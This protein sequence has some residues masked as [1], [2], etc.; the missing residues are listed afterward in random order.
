MAGQTFSASAPGKVIL[1]GEHAVVYGYPAIAVPVQ[2]LS[3]VVTIKES[4]ENGFGQILIDAPD[5]DLHTRLESL[6]LDHP[7]ALAITGT[8]SVL[9]LTNPL[10]FEIK[11]NSTI[12][13]AGGLGS[14]AAVSVAI[15]RALSRFFKIPLTN[16]QISNLAY[17]VE[18][19]H[20]GRPSGI[21]NTVITYAQPIFFQREKPFEILPP[22]HPFTLLI[23]DTGIASP[24]ASAV[25]GVR[26]RY[27]EN[28]NQYVKLFEEI[29]EISLL[30]RNI[31]NAQDPIQL[32]P[33]MN[34]NH[35]LLQQIG[36]SCDSLDRL[37][38]SAIAAGAYGAKLSGGGLG[39]N[40]IAL[41]PSEEIQKFSS[42]LIAN[43]AT[44]CFST[45][46]S[47]EIEPEKL[48]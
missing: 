17:E 30:A 3:A 15:I 2:Q 22:K 31:I 44:H 46:I 36:V 47:P 23:A 16:E 12:P 41:I 32:G 35:H 6:P 14:G 1:F 38:S 29:G 40:M 4:D 37:V 43:G 21:D 9:Q 10:S 28:P 8:L 7:L 11:I 27:E 18:K 42:L 33:L 25:A 39:G 24:T 13:I 5:I 45:V 20:H 26:Q 19:K 34:R 48:S